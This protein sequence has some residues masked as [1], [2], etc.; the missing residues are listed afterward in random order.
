MNNPFEACSSFRACAKYCEFGFKNKFF[1][2]SHSTHRITPFI[3]T[4]KEK[5]L[6]ATRKTVKAE[7]RGKLA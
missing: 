7:S 3:Q 6:S 2:P 5:P 4:S 1:S